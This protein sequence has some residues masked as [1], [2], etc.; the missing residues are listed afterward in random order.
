[1]GGGCHGQG[2]AILDICLQAISTTSL[3]PS[4]GALWVSGVVAAWKSVV[5]WTDDPDLCPEE[6]AKVQRHETELTVVST[7]PFQTGRGKHEDEKKNPNN[8]IIRT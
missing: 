2:L 1:M 8:I 3:Q 5:S 4:T 6:E 7:Q